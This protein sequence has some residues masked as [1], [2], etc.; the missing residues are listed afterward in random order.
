MADEEQVKKK[1]PNARI[2]HRQSGVYV[3]YRVVYDW[4]PKPICRHWTHCAA[5]DGR[6][7]AW[8]WAADKLD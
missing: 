5:N 2:E 6:L 4:P 8:K 7:L 3:Q 1:Y